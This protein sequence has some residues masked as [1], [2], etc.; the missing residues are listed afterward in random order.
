MWTIYDIH[1]NLYWNEERHCWCQMEDASC[2][3][4]EERD[5]VP[6]RSLRYQWRFI[7]PVLYHHK[8]APAAQ[9]N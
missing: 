5:H 1:S 4:F 2:Y 9:R 8:P 7:P 6:L 3:S